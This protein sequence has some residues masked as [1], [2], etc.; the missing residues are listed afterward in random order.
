MTRRRAAGFTLVELLI[1]LAIVGALLVIA[2]GGLRVALAAW[3]R[4][5]DRA[6]VHQELRGLALLMA[7]TVGATYPYRA[8]AGLAPEPV[9]LFRGTESRLELVTRAAPFPSGVPAAFVAVVL[10]IETDEQ[11]QLVVRQRVLPNR[12]PFTDA[13]PVFREPAIQQLEFRY[14]DEAG[15]W[16]ES[17]DADNENAL[18]T[19][20]RVTVSTTRGGRTDVLPAITVPLRLTP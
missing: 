6:G 10:A 19:A 5:E 1:A 3:T 12:N 9:L 17:W 7:R 11:P 16:Q 8:P 15:T 4:G 14:L 2:F 20:V 13:E 18:P